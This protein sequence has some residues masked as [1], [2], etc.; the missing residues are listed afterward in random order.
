MIIRIHLKLQKNHA[1]VA[2]MGDHQL[3]PMDGSMIQMN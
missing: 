1:G 3:F 2:A